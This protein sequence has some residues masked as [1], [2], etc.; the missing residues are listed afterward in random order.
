MPA[1]I[2]F[3]CG[4]CGYLEEGFR[5]EGRLCPSCRVEMVE[6]FS[7]STH[8]Q[9]RCPRGLEDGYKPRGITN[10]VFRAEL[11]LE[12]NG[13]RTTTDDEAAQLRSE[14]A[15]VGDDPTFIR[16]VTEGAKERAKRPRGL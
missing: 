10:P 2:D 11:G 15:R 6:A 3:I 4:N 7:P 9:W 1:L 5:G 8:F 14:Y 13:I 12:D 16:E